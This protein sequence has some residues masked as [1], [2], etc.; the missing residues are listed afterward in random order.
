MASTSTVGAITRS[1][2]TTRRASPDRGRKV[3]HLAQHWVHNGW[4]E[5]D[6]PAESVQVSWELHVAHRSAHPLRRARLSPAGAP[7]ALPVARRGDRSHAGGRRRSARPASTVSPG[8][9]VSA[10]CSSLTQVRLVKGR[11]HHDA[12]HGALAASAPAWT[13]TW[14]RREHWLVSS[15]W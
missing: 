10:T 1:L 15:S 13:K 3:E 8:A 4:V 6:E 2:R 5:V 7:G 12:D 9:S 14:T 11:D